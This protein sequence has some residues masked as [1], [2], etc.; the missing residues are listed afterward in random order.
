MAAVGETKLEARLFVGDSN[1][2]LLL[3]LDDDDGELVEF[4]VLKRKQSDRYIYINAISV[5]NININTFTY[6]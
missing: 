4:S 2:V 1:E 3:F 5:S 6:V